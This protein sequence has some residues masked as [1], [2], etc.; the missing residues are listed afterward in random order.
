MISCIRGESSRPPIPLRWDADGRKK[1]GS[2]GLPSHGVHVAVVDEDGY[3]WFV[4][5]RKCV[6][7]RGGKNVAPLE[8]E[9]TLA[10]HPAV[11][12]SCVIGVPEVHMIS[13]MPFK[14]PGKADGELLRMR[15]IT[16]ALIE[17]VP[18]FK[19]ASSEFLRDIIPRFDA[20]MFA[21]GDV[22]VYEGDVGDELYFL[23]RGQ[24]EVLRGERT[25]I[26]VGVLAGG[27]EG[28]P[29]SIEEISIGDREE[30]V[31]VPH[32]C[33]WRS[34]P[35]LNWVGMSADVV[36]VFDSGRAPRDT[37]VGACAVAARDRPAG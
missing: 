6:I 36:K 22:V 28:T 31:P 25:S 30:N 23:T 13:E 3:L 19:N 21:P 12:E 34:T 8:V 37:D 7:V 35:M 20:R 27:L 15:A 10:G 24:V 9:A 29:I 11:R 14:G 26:T 4:G 5:R 1:P 32:V 2:I 18:F 16:A 33:R 17:K